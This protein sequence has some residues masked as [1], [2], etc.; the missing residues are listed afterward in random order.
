MGRT[1]TADEAKD[2]LIELPLLPRPTVYHWR[3]PR[4]SKYMELARLKDHLLVTHGIRWRSK[5]GPKKG[6]KNR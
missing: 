2:E 6:S 1:W 3:C 5:P 4:C